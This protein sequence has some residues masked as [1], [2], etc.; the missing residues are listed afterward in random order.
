MRLS[1]SV[2]LCTGVCFGQWPTP[3]TANEAYNFVQER[4]SS[5]GK[6][7]SSS[8]QRG[9]DMLNET[10]RYLDQLS[11]VTSPPEIHFLLGGGLTFISIWPKPT[12]YRASRGSPLTTCKRYYRRPQPG[13]CSTPSGKIVDTLREDPEFKQL[14]VQFR[15]YEAC[16]I[17][18][19]ARHFAKNISDAEKLADSENSVGGQVQL[20]VSREADHT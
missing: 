18:A 9:I 8:D 20:R 7:W 6:L 12:R 17:P 10:L 5:A 16:G 15:R 4:R 2:L 3:K 11:F 1:L 13:N 14:L 19:L